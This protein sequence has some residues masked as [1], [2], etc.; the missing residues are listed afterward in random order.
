MKSVSLGFDFRSEHLIFSSICS[1]NFALRHIRVS[2]SDD[3]PIQNC[4]RK[5]GI[6]NKE[7]LSIISE[8]DDPFKILEDFDALRK[9]DLE[10][11]PT[12][13]TA[14]QA[15]TQG[16][17]PWKKVP[18]KK[19]QKEERKLRPV[20]SSKKIVHVLLRYDKIKTKK[21]IREKRR[22]K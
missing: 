16:G 18:L 12:E 15:R 10:L 11:A 19:S 13:V 5:G 8:E 4:F 7:R 22:Y 17:A 1:V 2:L 20:M 3:E 9:K 21:V 14:A 6:W